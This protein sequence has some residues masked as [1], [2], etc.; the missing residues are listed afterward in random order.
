MMN[1]LSYFNDG[2]TDTGVLF[3]LV[4][5]DTALA[6]SFQIKSKRHLLSSTLL[7]GLL[8]NFCLCFMP[9]LVTGLSH[10][11]P[12]SDG[13]YQMISAILAIYIGYAILQSILAYAQLWG[14]NYPQWL[15]NWLSQ[16]VRSKEEKVEPNDRN[17]VDTIRGSEMG[18]Q[19]EQSKKEL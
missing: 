10:F 8:R 11:H 9:I 3:I 17:S 19:S 18:R 2:I 7:A 4:L 16:E 12:R 14:I 15:Q 5:I 6:L 1:Y 13:L